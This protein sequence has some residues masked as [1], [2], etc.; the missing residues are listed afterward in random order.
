MLLRL[1]IEALLLVVALVIGEKQPR[2]HRHP[3]YKLYAFVSLY[4]SRVSYLECPYFHFEKN[5]ASLFQEY[6]ILPV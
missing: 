4:N 3:G 1:V 2:H 6:L 5:A